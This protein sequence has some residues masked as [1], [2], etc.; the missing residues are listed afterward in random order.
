MSKQVP[1]KILLRIIQEAL[2]LV[3][4]NHTD[5]IRSVGGIIL[6]ARVEATSRPPGE[7]TRKI[8]SMC[9]DPS[10]FVRMNMCGTLRSLFRISR[11]FEEKAL[12]EVI[13]LVGDECLEVL[14]ESLQVF[15]DILPRISDKGTILESIE[16]YFVK[17]SYDKLI[18][19]KLMFVGRI[20][21]QCKDCMESF[22]K[23]LWVDWV[24][25]MIELGTV[26][27]KRSATISLGGILRC[28]RLTS[29]IFRL[30]KILEEENDREIEKNLILLL[31][32]L[33]SFGTEMIAET[34]G[35]IRKY[36]KNSEHALII[37]PQFTVIATSFEMSEEILQILIE[38][39]NFSL[40][41]Q[42]LLA[43]IEQIISFANN[44]ECIQ[45]LVP[46]VPSLI[47]ASKTCT[48]PIKEKSLELLSIIL[49]KCNGYS[50]KVN[51]AN[52]IINNFANSIVCY[53]RAAYIHFCLCIKNLCSR[54]FFSK[55]FMASLL[56]LAEDKVR[57]VRYTF[58]KNYARFRF[59]VPSD[60][61]E[62]AANFRSILNQYLE[63]DDAILLNF[64]LAAD[65]A[66]SNNTI[67]EMHYGSKGELVEKQ[68]VK[69]EQ[70]E[71]IKEITDMENLKKIQQE[72]IVK[73]VRKNPKKNLMSNNT[74]PRQSS[75]RPIKRNHLS[76]SDKYDSVI[77]RVAV[78]IARKK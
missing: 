1:E 34:Q 71:E 62:L 38:K 37:I 33:S 49:Y 44:F 8:F 13:K 59:Q 20:L 67:R 50:N 23:D 26:C 19:M 63:I 55:L 51:L 58:A 17:S 28:A 35:I 39:L 72:E 30:W 25:R 70:T 27:D 4:F 73:I 57:L 22:K 12:Q 54:Q 3:A 11:E 14:S 7:I 53:N 32:H 31:G 52:E 6:G 66:I 41:R 10:N 45:N 43:I 69:Y 40:R 74:V 68:R 47:Q 60:D 36:L 65:E 18:C 78:R 29:K 56:E 64:A 15:V 42:E 16:E 61:T 77:S 9:Q 48:I 46:L 76:E 5:G 75:V 21:E 2:A 24:I